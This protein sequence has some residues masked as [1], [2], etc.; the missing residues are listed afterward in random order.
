MNEDFE[1]KASDL[2]DK[3]G[4]LGANEVSGDLLW[5]VEVENFA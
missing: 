1:I 5:L 2:D 3:G 4:L